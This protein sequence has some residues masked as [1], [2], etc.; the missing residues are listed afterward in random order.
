MSLS[1]AI[2]TGAT[3]NPRLAACLESSMVSIVVAI[4]PH[5]QC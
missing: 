1:L 2:I 4:R 5:K 3:H